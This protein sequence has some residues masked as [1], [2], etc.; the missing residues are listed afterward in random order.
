MAEKKLLEATLG[1]LVKDE[2]VWLSMKKRKIGAGCFNGY[3]GGTEKGDKNLVEALKREVKEECGVQ[4]SE[5]GLAK[6]AIIDF[7]NT[8]SKGETFVA[9]VHVFLIKNWSGEPQ[10]TSEM[11]AP[12]KFAMNNLPF[13]KMMPADKEWLPLVLEGKKIIAEYYY[14]PFQK[15]LIKEGKIKVVKSF[16]EKF[17]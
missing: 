17:L 15:E 8:T 12:T 4:I 14:G 13:E 9:K 1:F 16:P 11:K 2:F 7:H 10:E 5:K 3:G 6:M